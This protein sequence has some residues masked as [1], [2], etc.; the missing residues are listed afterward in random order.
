MDYA[1]ITKQG[2]RLINSHQY[3]KTAEYIERLHHRHPNNADL[4]NILTN[5]SCWLCGHTNDVLDI[6]RSVYMASISIDNFEQYLSN[7]TN[8]KN[9]HLNFVVP[10]M[11]PKSGGTFIFNVLHSQ[12]GYY[13]QIF[14]AFGDASHAMFSMERLAVVAKYGHVL[15]HNHPKPN[16]HNISVIKKLGIPI[17]IH[18]RDPR[19]AFFSFVNM[20][21]NA[22]DRFKKH[23]D[24]TF[25]YN[26]DANTDFWPSSD[27]LYDKNILAQQTMW[28]MDW[29]CNWLNGWL[30]L[31]YSNKIITRYEELQNNEMK[32]LLKINQDVLGNE[33]K[34]DLYIPSKNF[35]KH[36]FVAGK[37]AMWRKHLSKI[38]IDLIEDK[39][40]AYH[41]DR[42]FK[43]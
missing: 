21:M 26:N 32:F 5:L 30:D 12:I 23:F 18:I 43:N 15:L 39:F 16:F 28:M 10:I 8:N 9:Y 1:D 40:Y 25:V 35:T 36:R 2:L 33:P 11:Q 20:Y 3:R 27:L 14:Y 29:Y 41:M 4:S 19:D 38:N 13:N 34:T 7:V 17:W 31:D 37:K 42:Y 22:K 24:T 6:E